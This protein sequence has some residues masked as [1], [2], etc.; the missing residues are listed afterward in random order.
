[1]SG[2]RVGNVRVLERAARVGPKS[3]HASGRGRGSCDRPSELPE[4][5]DGDLRLTA[6]LRAERPRRRNVPGLRLQLRP[7]REFR[8]GHGR[9]AD[10][11]TARRGRRRSC[12]TT[13]GPTSSRS[14]S[15]STSVRGEA[16]RLR[17][18]A[19]RPA[20]V[21]DAAV[22]IH[23]LDR[24]HCSAASVTT[25]L[26]APGADFAVAVGCV[27]PLG[28]LLDVASWANVRTGYISC[29]ERATAPAIPPDW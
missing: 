25:R 14:A 13:S 5:L 20:A 24:W 17:A 12:A 27:D 16:V 4:F 2:L 28:Q 26:L 18:P 6:G 22:S 8:A 3:A 10:G 23:G 19:D 21:G 29:R 1:M 9:P 7:R 15:R 11:R